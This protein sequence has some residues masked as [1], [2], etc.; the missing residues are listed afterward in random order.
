M[1]T[2]IDMKFKKWTIWDELTEEA[3]DITHESFKRGLEYK[4]IELYGQFMT[5]ENGHKI[6][7]DAIYKK[8]LKI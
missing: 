4:Y 2:S 5:V 1:K 7:V 6:W 8:I 3:I